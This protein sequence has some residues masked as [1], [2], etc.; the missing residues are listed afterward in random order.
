MSNESADVAPLKNLGYYRRRKEFT[1]KHFLP[2]NLLV[3]LDKY[4]DDGCHPGDFLE[5]CL[6]N[7]FMGAAKNADTL[8]RSLMW[9]VAF[10]IYN[11]M[12]VGSHG[13][14]EQVGRWLA[15]GHQDA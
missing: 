8:S 14:Y 9:L 4:V 11:V 6:A 10:Y 1:D 3:S 2:Q 13:S 15:G 5:A 12:P 7:D